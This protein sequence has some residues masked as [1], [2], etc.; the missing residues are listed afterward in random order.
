MSEIAEE[1]AL[2]LARLRH[3]CLP[4]A[5]VR[6]ADVERVAD[7]AGRRVHVIEDAEN[8]SLLAL[9]WQGAEPAAST[10]SPRLSRRA[11]SPK[12][13]RT[14]VVVHALLSDPHTDR[15]VV[16]TAQVLGTVELLMGR[17]GNS[18]VVPTLRE[19][20]PRAGL[21]AAAAGGWRAGPMMRAWD[22]P[23]RD[24]MAHAARGLW[25]HPNWSEIPDAQ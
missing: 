25:Q 6:V 15:T 7:M 16:T 22:A 2:A 9:G 20:L 12:A 14:L 8:G 17:A 4:A 3:R 13:T 18:W 21:V 23:T 24:V 1:V 11:L 5:G 19:T 10:Q